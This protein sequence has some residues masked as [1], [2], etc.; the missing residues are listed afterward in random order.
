MRN[1]LSLWRRRPSVLV[2]LAMACVA[3]KSVVF[4][5]LRAEAGSLVIPA[6]SFARGNG[7]I[8]ADPGRYADAGPVVGSG[9]KQPWGWSIE[10]DIDIPVDG[11]YSLHICYSAAEARPVEVFLDNVMLRKTCTGVTFSRK[12]DKL[13]WNSSGARWDTIMLPRE[14]GEI[15]KGFHTVKITSRRPL[16]HLVALRLETNEAFPGSWEPPQF[17]VSNLEGIP[18]AHRKA[19]KPAGDVDVAAL[20]LPV[21]PAPRNRFKGSLTVPACTFDRGNARIY[22]SPNQYANLG[23]LAGSI[24]EGEQAEGFVEYDID[25]PVA[26]EYTFQV[27]YSAYEARPLDVFLDGKKLGKCCTAVTFGSAPFSRP[28]KFSGN[29]RDAV[30]EG[31]SEKGTPVKLSLTEGRHTL[32]FARRGPLPHLMTLRLDTTSEFPRDWKQAARKVRYIDRVPARQRTAFLPPDA[33][34]VAALRLAIKDMIETLGQRYPDGQKHLKELSELEARQKSA[35]SGTEEQKQQVEQ[36]LAALRRRAMLTHPALNFDK[37]LFLKRKECG[38]HHIYGDHDSKTTGGNLCV[39]SPVTEEG[40]VTTLVPEL[41]DGLFWRFDLSYDAKKVVFD[42]KKPDGAFRIYEIDIDPEAGRMVPGSLRQLTFESDHEA[43]ALQCN[44]RIGRKHDRGFNDMA[45]CY[46]P[47]GKI[48]FTSTRSMR[49]VFCAGTTVTTLYIMDADGKN[50]RCLSAS[51]L[52]ELS[53]SMMDDGRVVY[54]RW[55]Y[56]DKGLGNGQSVW[57]VRPDGSGVDHVYKNNTVSPAGMIFTRSIPGSQKIV[58][59]AAPHCGPSVGP[60]VLVDAREGKRRTEAMDCITPAVGYPG[61]SPVPAGFGYFKDPYPFSEKFFL[62]SHVPG[63]DRRLRREEIPKYGIYALDA[64]G[65][66][67]KLYGDPEISSFQPIP[68]RSRRK[69]ME[70]AAA[71]AVDTKREK[72]GTLFIQNVYEGMTGIERGRVKYLRVM[73]VLEWPWGESGMYRIGLNVDVHRKKVYGVVKVHEDGSVYFKAPANENILFQALDEDF[74]VLQ[75]MATFINL[76]PGERRSCIGC[77]EHRRKAPGMSRG[78]PIAMEH[79]PQTL[80]PQPGDTGPRTVHY[81]SDV[82]AVL[83]KRCV[84]CHSGEKP[85]AHLDLAGVPTKQWSRSYE[86]LIGRGLIDYRD[87]RY[88]RAGFEAVPPLTHGSHLSKLTARI[89][90]G[91]CKADLTREEFIRI[92]TWID[93]NAPFYGTYRGK[94]DLQYKDAPD[95]RLPPLVQR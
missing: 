15:K 54:T 26:G 25:V 41:D 16:P 95:F 92:V 88:G 2:V 84:G 65:N 77:H 91:P 66:R 57:S 44:A 42:Y 80:V 70:I 71:E 3:A 24:I 33:V 76:N 23:P 4:P 6:W 37:L 82:Q 19:F 45:P 43:E 90:K 59:V 38:S 81:D 55:E 32:K 93:A 78:R 62:V 48:M 36:S 56:V 14:V 61:M 89:R 51:P 27:R 20:R 18:A 64:W 8:Y 13:T 75:H 30:W 52:T 60:V 53:P 39:L 94:R 63:Y 46:L 49:N 9:E 7:R 74:M 29:S 72:T 79:P 22:A 17:K 40:K 69:P 83:D 10:Y 50:M 73:G 58:T 21:E 67:A 31:L 28:V 35:E 34:N 68:L 12:G 11:K 85:K 47:N 86:N 87:G 1:E 5:P